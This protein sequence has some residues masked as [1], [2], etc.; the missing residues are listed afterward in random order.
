M[1]SHSSLLGIRRDP[2]PRLRCDVDAAFV[3]RRR[4]APMVGDGHVHD[5][6]LHRG[7]GRRAAKFG[8]GGLLLPSP[9]EPGGAG[10]GDGQSMQTFLLLGR[11]AV[12]EGIS[13]RTTT[14][15]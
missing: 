13:V 7:I 6:P 5:A 12:T 2:K 15:P 3:R 14:S 8:T 4:H 11:P 9:P 1:T 10:E